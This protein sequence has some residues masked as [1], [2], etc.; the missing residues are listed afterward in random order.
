VTTPESALDAAT[1][2]LDGGDPYTAFDHLNAVI[3]HPNHPDDGGVFVAA[4]EA[5]ARATGDIFPDATAAIGAVVAAPD[6]V[7]ALYAAGY[8]LNEAALPAFAAS[9]LFRAGAIAPAELRVLTERATSLEMLGE[10]AAAARSVAQ[11]HPALSE[12]FMPRYLHAFEGGLAGDLAPARALHPWLTKRAEGDAERFMAE[13]IGAWIA[14]ADAICGVDG[15]PGP[16]DLRGWHAVL[17]G[18]VVLEVADDADGAG[19]GR[20]GLVR[21]SAASARR[22]IT[23]VGATLEALGTPPERVYHLEE[24]RSRALAEA[25]GAV[26]SAP[27]VA[28]T[29][30][31][32]AP[33]VV[34]AFDL[35]KVGSDQQGGLREAR[36]GVVLWDHACQW[37]VEARLT[38]DLT[39]ALSQQVKPLWDQPDAAVSE[40]AA[41]IAEAD[42]EA[43]T[44]AVVAATKVARALAA[45][46]GPLRDV[47]LRPKRW[48]WG[49]GRA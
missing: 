23:T 12:E 42:G 36:P 21:E 31:A 18:G 32:T 29:P 15:Q 11:V 25:A 45:L 37:T 2:A 8:A 47:G 46:G 48:P 19:L 24:R 28:W 14:R 16:K 40:I 4:L 33:G 7:D 13:R 10:Y 35:R 41:A 3:G 34:V 5:L 9:L 22:A 26:W 44:D 49:T 17:F 43:H 6:D 27:V 30:A 39:T 38:G 20:F 1:V